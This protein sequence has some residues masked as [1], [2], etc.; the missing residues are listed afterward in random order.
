MST[1]LGKPTK[2]RPKNKTPVA[3]DRESLR[4]VLP[5][6]RGPYAPNDFINMEVRAVDTAVANYL[7]RHVT[8]LP[9]R[10]ARRVVFQIATEDPDPKKEKITT[11]AYRDLFRDQA[12]TQWQHFVDQIP[13][14]FVL[15]ALGL[16]M[17]WISNYLGDLQHLEDGLR[18][19]LS[20]TAQVGAWVALWT[21]IAGIFSVGF[22]SL[23]KNYAL[24]RLAQAQMSFVYSS[25]GTHVDDDD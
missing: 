13:L 9:W 14:T 6:Y 5:G 10:H 12:S 8:R 7:I 16:C 2:S 15:A 21:A 23:Q 24:R 25:E 3:T 4:I 11:E 1:V 17:L 19:T 22:T 20:D 18:K